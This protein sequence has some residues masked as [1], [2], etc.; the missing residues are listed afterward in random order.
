VAV[1]RAR[2]AV[3][4]ARR[5]ARADPSQRARERS[6]PAQLRVRIRISSF[7]M[8]F[9]RC[10]FVDQTIDF[11]VGKPVNGQGAETIEAPGSFRIS[12]TWFSAALPHPTTAI[13]STR[14][15]PRPRR[16]H[17]GTQ[18]VCRTLERIFATPI[19]NATGAEGELARQPRRQSGLG[20]P[21]NRRIRDRPLGDHP[22]S[23]LT[24]GRKAFWGADVEPRAIG[25]R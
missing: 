12:R 9:E 15:P 7:W 11:D 20:E 4:A 23:P 17:V 24:R 5:Q 14:K 25:R 1:R 16:P 10:G 8:W 3:P 21:E 18:E 13:Q 6:A 2:T 22:Y 19:G